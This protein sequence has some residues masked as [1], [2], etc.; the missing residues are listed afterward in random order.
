MRFQDPLRKMV[1][2]IAQLRDIIRKNK[3]LYCIAIF[4]RNRES[5][6]RVIKVYASGFPSRQP[7]PQSLTKHFWTS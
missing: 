4:E 5:T 1:T 2:V 7:L 3:G 6:S